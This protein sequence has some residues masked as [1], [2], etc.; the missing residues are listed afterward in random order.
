MSIRA[1]MHSGDAAAVTEVTG[2]PGK[3]LTID[4]ALEGG[5]GS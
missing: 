2:R 4:D 3:F 5:E 1:A